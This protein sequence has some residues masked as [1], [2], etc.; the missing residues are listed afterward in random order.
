MKVGKGITFT[1]LVLAGAIQALAICSPFDGVS[2]GWLQIICLSLLI[3]VID[4]CKKQKP[5]NVIGQVVVQ[6]SYRSIFGK[7]LVFAT[8]WLSTTFWWIYISLHNYGGMPALLAL[9]SVVVLAL[10]LSLYYASVCTLYAYLSKQG[11]WGLDGVLFGSLWTIAELAR[12]QWFTGFPWGAIGYAHIDNS[13]KFIAPYVGVY[14]IGFVAAFLAFNLSMLCSSIWEA[15]KGDKQK[16]RF[17]T[18]GMNLLFCLLIWP[19]QKVISEIERFNN[20]NINLTQVLSYSLLQGNVPQEIKFE[21]E[22]L[23]A[24][25]WYKYQILRADTQLIVTPETA[26]PVLKVNLPPGY[27]QEITEHIET[28]SRQEQALLMGIIGE[29][30]GQ[31][32]NRVVG[33]SGN[34]PNYIYDKHHLVPFG[35]FIPAWFK[36]FTDLMKIPLG[37]FSRGNL[38]QGPWETIGQS[39]AVNVCYEDVFGEELA[40][41]FVTKGEKVPTLMVNVSNIGWFGPF[42]AVE[43]HL[44][45]SRMRAIEMGRPMLRATN[46]GA[47]AAI[48]HNGYVKSM[49]PKSTKGVL[50]GEIQG[51][52]G[53]ATPYAQWSGRYSLYPLWGTCLALVLF[54]LGLNLKR[55]NSSRFERRGGK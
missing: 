4:Y 47:T 28:K 17:I 52:V 9:A 48:D 35:E 43:Q 24:I 40:V 27:W 10:G 5:K 37:S 12:A 42:M 45:A 8:S 21:E 15:F 14:G 11:K 34:K 54:M 41:A 19:N 26:I 32:S 46:T 18:I 51:V 39:I 3:S 55:K 53:S 2:R 31:Y 7:A 16:I 22:G 50:T 25:N 33:I 36:W 1:L 23:K 6:T 29:S 13:L 20:Q 49:L 30:G 44:N 38:S